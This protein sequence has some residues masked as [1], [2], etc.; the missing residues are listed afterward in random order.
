M[1]F[2]CQGFWVDPSVACSRR[3]SGSK[4]VLACFFVLPCAS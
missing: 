4:K 3:Q 1:R 2:W